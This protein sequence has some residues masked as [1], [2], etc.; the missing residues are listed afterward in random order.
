MLVN[1]LSNHP[2]TGPP[3]NMKLKTIFKRSSVS[4]KKEISKKIE[5]NEEKKLIRIIK[6]SKEPI[7]KTSSA[8]PFDLFPDQVSIEEYKV[9]VTNYEFFLTKR[10]HSI[11]VND[12]ADVFVDTAPFFATLKI[13]YRSFTENTVQVRFLKKDDALRARR[14]IE[15]LVIADKNHID[16]AKIKREHLMIELEELGKAKQAE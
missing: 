8:F 1:I 11:A 15:G 16:L 9:N 4:P 14:I 13:I 6:A 5:K 12:I 2:S 10:V 7:F 3:K